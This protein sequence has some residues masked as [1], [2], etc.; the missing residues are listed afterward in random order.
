MP[1]HRKVS[2]VVISFTQLERIF[3]IKCSCFFLIVEKILKKKV[4]THRA[5]FFSFDSMATHILEKV[6]IFESLKKAAV[7]PPLTQPYLM[8]CCFDK[9]SADSIG[10]TIRSTVKNAA[11]KLLKSL[12]AL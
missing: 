5:K 12:L 11:W 6:G 2:F 4:L 8:M 7:D 9:S 3:C 1:S 10:D